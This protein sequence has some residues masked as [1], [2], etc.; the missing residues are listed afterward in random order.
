[1]IQLAS[2]NYR[3]HGTSL[4]YFVINLFVHLSWII[5]NYLLLFFY[6]IYSHFQF[7]LF[8]YS[9]S[10]HQLLNI[11]VCSVGSLNYSVYC[12]GLV[13]SSSVI[14]SFYWLILFRKAHSPDHRCR[15][16]PTHFQDHCTCLQTHQKRSQCK[17]NAKMQIITS[18]QT[19]LRV[20]GVP[21]TTSPLLSFPFPAVLN[22]LRWALL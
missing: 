11:Y 1:M 12:F 10:W 3:L 20:A 13:H 17:L 22:C 18:M 16:L 2:V 9:V 14:V 5:F 8:L 6:G 21:P 15:G 4:V 19:R 7:I